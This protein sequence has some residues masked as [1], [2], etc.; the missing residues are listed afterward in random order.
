MKHPKNEFPFAILMDNNHFEFLS[1]PTTMTTSLSFATLP[2]AVA[3]FVAGAL[4]PLQ[5]GSNAALGRALGHP[6]WAS[7]ASLTVSLLVVLPVLLATRAHAPLI[8][9]ALQRPLWTWLGGLAGVIYITLALI[10][11]PRLG[12]TTFI[13]CVVAGQTLASLLIDHYGLMGLAQ[14]LATP[15]RIAGVALIF[16]GMIVVQWQTPA[17][18]APAAPGDAAAVQPEPQH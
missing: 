1:R 9:D 3:A 4:V 14:R 16:A 2:L 5:G 6:L 8:G 10:L 17:P 11:T 7:V 18:R 15:G 12:A 13:V